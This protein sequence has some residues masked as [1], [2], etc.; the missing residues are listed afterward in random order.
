MTKQEW[1]EE[2]IFVDTYGRP[3]N[4]SVVPMTM[5]PRHKAFKK[6]GYD[7]NTIDDIWNKVKEEYNG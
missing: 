3:Y 7:D 1:L 5:M 4:L 2:S 6:R